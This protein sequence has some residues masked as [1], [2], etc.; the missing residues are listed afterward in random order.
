MELIL[1]ILAG[2]FAAAAV[3]LALGRGRL[4]ADAAA[5][6][7]ERDAA[8][9]ERDRIRSEY[10]AQ[11]S[12][13][14]DVHSRCNTLET[15]LATLKSEHAAQATA[16]AAELQSA[17]ELHAERVRAL[18]AREQQLKRDFA[19][20]DAELK[21]HF[22]AL[23]ADAL[24]GSNDAFLTLAQQTFQKHQQTATAELDKRKTAVDE[25]IKPIADT[26][27]Q[28]R[29]RLDGLA[30]TSDQL[31][32]ETVR[33]VRALAK[34]EIRGRYGEIQLR[35]VAEI[36]GMRPY[37]DFDEQTSQRDDSGQLKRPD[38]IVRLPN[39]RVIA[40]DAKANLQA[41]LEAANAKTPEEQEAHLER[42]ARHVSDQVAALSRKQYWAEL[43]GSPEFVVMFVPGDQFLDAALA[44]RPDLIE[45]A[46]EQ[47]IILAS[48]STLI[49]LLRAVAVGWRERSLE[50][51]AR[52]LFNL[53]KQLHDRAAVAFEH[54]AGLGKAIE[55]TA[56]RYNDMLGS[57]ESRL[58]P[59]IRRFDA[60]PAKSGKELPDLRT[61]DVNLRR[62]TLELPGGE[63]A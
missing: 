21:E 51:Q 38:M 4:Q 49:G 12:V 36:A 22:K 63:G 52:E 5:A 59:A 19:T 44:R 55:Q 1:G 57:F 20:R 48:P 31:K 47:N 6:R 25:L 62:P 34:P 27:A 16:H 29:T 53:G 58:L 56:S 18:E 30:A 35:R 8:I 9:G 24:K 42:F 45:K 41:F 50:D 15:H 10:E 11:A 37:C 13:L 54:V 32:D 46:A 7:A 28:T 43:E 39:D 26:L 14:R 40:V 23:A 33:L 60:S 3:W 61:V 2:L 17:H